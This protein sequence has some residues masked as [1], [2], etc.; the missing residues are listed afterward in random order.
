MKDCQGQ[1]ANLI[2]LLSDPEET[3]IRAAPVAL[4]ELTGQKLGSNREVW[5]NW[6]DKQK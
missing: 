6:R 1:V 2:P 3:V 4:K 5:Q